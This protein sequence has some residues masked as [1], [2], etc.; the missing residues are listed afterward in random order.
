MIVDAFKDLREEKRGNELDQKN[1]CFICGTN[2]EEFEK[3]G[4]DF[5]DHT[6]IDHNI[7]NY[8]F[9]VMFVMEKF[10]THPT[11]VNEVES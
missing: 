2:R 7:W 9:F 5:E 8:M 1:V 11:E 4:I 3:K 6:R 10:D